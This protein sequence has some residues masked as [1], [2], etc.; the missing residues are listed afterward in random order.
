MR[1]PL[2]VTG[3][4]MSA[5]LLLVG[6]SGGGGL[7]S[8]EMTDEDRAAGEAPSIDYE[9]PIKVEGNETKVLDEGDGEDIDPGDTLM[10]QMS[11]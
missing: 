11:I 7:R 3:T 8:V 6:C 5:A 2:L 4:A 1:K 10:V 9:T